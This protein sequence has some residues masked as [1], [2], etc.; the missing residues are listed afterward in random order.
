MQTQ[1]ATPT[2]DAMQAWFKANDDRIMYLRGRW[3]D[4]RDY[5]DFNDYKAEI[6]K[7]LAG[8]DFTFVSMTRGW[9]ITVVYKPNG[10][11]GTIKVNCGSVKFK[12]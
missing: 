11:T 1:S 10:R 3:Q 12:A 9:V 4:E 7:L 5:E 8:T 6:V 2:L